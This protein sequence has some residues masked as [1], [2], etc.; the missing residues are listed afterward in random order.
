MRYLKPLSLLSILFISICG[1]SQNK[2]GIGV[3]VPTEAL[4]VDRGVNIDHN[5]QNPGSSLLNGL[6]FGNT[7]TALQMVGISSNRA[8][9]TQPYSLDF[10]TSNQKRMTILQSGLVGINTVPTGYFL[11]VG[12]TV[13]GITL[14]SEGSIY[15]EGGSVNAN[16]SVTAG[17]NITAGNNI[18]ATTGDIIA[19]SG[20]LKAGGRG[21]VMSNSGTRQRM[22]A[23]TATL[24]VT[25]LGVGSSVTGSISIGAGTFTAAP[26]AYVG[27]VI[28]ENGEYYK[29]MLVLENV[30]TS[31]ITIR[32]VNVA[33]DAVSFSGAQ[34]KIMAIGAF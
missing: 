4:S 18:T 15:A 29:V 16:S 33:S 17:T 22:V 34:W 19:T 6:R 5:N 20:E 11:E 23:Y 8:G 25:G 30:T 3:T 28:T 2:V 24:S 32:V 27:N 31:N 21:V 14:R 12:G 10:Y 13:R 26:T 7:A 1:S 9:A